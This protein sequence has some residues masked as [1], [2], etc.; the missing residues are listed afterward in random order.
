MAG[1]S[2][3]VRVR[4]LRVAFLVNPKDKLSLL[5][6]IEACSFLWGSTYNS[7]IPVYKKTPKDLEFLSGGVKLKPKEIIAGYLEAF[8]PDIV[9]PVGVIEGD[10]FDVGYRDLV[11]CNE[12]ISGLDKSH[13]SKFGV[14]FFEVLSD[15]VDKEFKFKRNDQH[16]LVFP[17]LDVNCQTFLASVFGKLPSEAD[18]ILKEFYIS[19][20][21]VKTP[22]INISNFLDFLSPVNLFPRRI[23]SWAIEHEPYR[24]HIIF[25][26]DAKSNQDII[27]YWNLMAAGH[28]VFPIPLQICKDD[29]TKEFVCAFIQKYFLPYRHNPNMFHKAIVQKSRCLSEEDFDQFCIA[30]ITPVDKKSEESKWVRRSW[31]PRIWDAWARENIQERVEKPYAY[32]VEINVPEIENRL[33]LRSNDP[34]FKLMSD[35]SGNAKFANDFSFRFYS[36]SE[37]MAE[38][39]PEGS[40]ELSSAIGRTGFQ[41][42]RFSESGPVFLVKHSQDLI[43]IELPRAE[44]VMI[45]WLRERGW[46]ATLSH[47]GRIA[48]QL[49]KQLGGIW[50]ISWLAKKGV[51]DLLRELEKERGLSSSKIVEKL[52]KIISSE[53]LHIESSRF[54]EILLKANAIKLGVSI[55]CPVCTRHNWY[56]LNTFG[57]KIHCQ[58]CMSDFEV[59]SHEPKN[60]IEWN[61]RSQGPFTTTYSQGAYCVLFVLKFL[62]R[63][64]AFENSLTP[65]FSYNAKKENVDLEADLTCLYKPSGWKDPR[66]RIIHAECKSF[67][68]FMAK[69]FER[70][71][72]LGESFPG[73]ALIFA[74]LKDSLNKGE[75]RSIKSIV[76]S[77]RKKRFKGLENSPIIILT[78]NELFS[79]NGAPNCWIDKGGK[80][81]NF[82]RNRAN[83]SDLF[84]LGEATQQLYL[85]IESWDD[86]YDEKLNQ[87]K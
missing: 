71:K 55:K 34:K 79:S 11:K 10:E 67:N 76:N 23:T 65:L 24:E 82:A 21:D 77:Q 57:Y 38:V 61:Y 26:C 49:F 85:D 20:L 15:L 84:E 75:V 63:G 51:L 47:S 16:S 45:E 12:L 43:F 25:I 31:Y 36:N 2:I 4:P 64:G 78:A 3:S 18:T 32:E 70:M 56:D 52:K 6:A 13:T 37:P 17:D 48:L 50:G 22:R 9:V 14:G 7:I 72:A 28:I 59:P 53:K 58:F 66:T 74:T 86:W 27:D 54:L 73:S 69:D 30:L 87:S 19:N 33:D 83:Y 80:Y 39:F 44:P 60:E 1:G 29:K 68:S 62:S 46:K 35:Y 42:W 5:S 40:R 81:L 8:D 41:N